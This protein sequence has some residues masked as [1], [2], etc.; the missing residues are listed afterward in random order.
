M[1]L[2]NKLD[3]KVFP[4]CTYGK[5]TFVAD[6][7]IIYETEIE[8]LTTIVPDYMDIEKIVDENLNDQ[9][10]IAEHIPFIVKRELEKEI[11]NFVLISVIV[12][13]SSP[14]HGD[15]R[16]SWTKEE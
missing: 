10:L 4:Y 15:V 11:N 7:T 12:H 2:Q 5:S 13:A 14:V 3:R 8:D 1:K 9:Q 6:V 16:V